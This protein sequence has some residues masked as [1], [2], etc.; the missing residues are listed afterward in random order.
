MHTLCN[1]IRPTVW[2]AALL[3]ILVAASVH[4]Q[5]TQRTWSSGATSGSWA[6][7]GNWSGG[8]APSSGNSI[9]FTNNAQTTMTNDLNATNRYTGLYMH[10]AAGSDRLLVGNFNMFGEFG[11]ANSKIEVNTGTNHRTLTISGNVSV[12]GNTNNP[13]EINPVGGSIIIGGSISDFGSGRILRMF[14]NNTENDLVRSVTVSNGITG[15]NG[16]LQIRNYANLIL[17]G[18]STYTNNTEIDTG[19]VMLG[20]GS[21]DGTLNTNS[22]IYVGNG[23][24]NGNATLRFG[25][26]NGGQ[27]L[28]AGAILQI[29]ANGAGGIRT[30]RS[31]NTSG[32][33]TI[34]RTINN[35]AQL[36]ITNSAGGTLRFAG[37]ITNSANSLVIQGAGTNAVVEFAAANSFS[38]VFVDYGHVKFDASNSWGTGRISLGRN[39]ADTRAAMASFSTNLTVGAAFEAR[40]NASRKI[41]QYSGGAGTLTLTGAITNNASGTTSGL[42]LDVASGGT[43]HSSGAL[44]GGGTPV[45]TKTGAGVF[46]ASGS[47]GD[48][49]WNIANGTVVVGANGALSTG[50]STGV[51]AIDLGF[52]GTG[53]TANNVALYASNGV[54]VSNSIYVAP[55]DSSSTRTIGVAA[56]SAAATFNNEIYLHGSARLEAGA[57]SQATFSGNLINTAG[58]EKIGAGTVTLSGNNT[59]SGDTLVSAGTLKLD[60]ASGGALAATDSVSVDDTAVLLLSRSNQVNDSAAVTLSGGT[61]QRDGEV[62]E[63]FGN[64]NLTQA[65][66][67][68]YGSG[69]VGQLRFGTYSAEFLLTVGNFAAGNTLL[70]GSDLTSVITDTEL[71]SFGSEISYDWDGDTSTFTITAIPE[72]SA[73]AAAAGLLGMMLWP[74]RR[75][76]V[77]D[78]KRILG[79]RAP[80][81]DRLRRAA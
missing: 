9:N 35:N 4:A 38:N 22:A 49:K 2:V 81:R 1:V 57:S 63:V 28:A 8:T 19:T 62:N 67:L 36:F 27:T 23:A 68:D 25:K 46:I 26:T 15:G 40:T 10:S 69:P 47:A 61:I 41:I 71:F 42:E 73:Y 78:T 21:N 75:R 44:T 65:S 18:T 53:S 50:T 54:T 12:G 45:F 11:G 66:F 13:Y 80:M 51:R 17:M 77:R 52:D 43:M 64:L 29:N 55:N 79:L 6:T 14:G 24:V 60:S 34:E 59:F 30:I 33:N 3:S 7:S 58:I 48:N 20:Q 31:D 37:A 16:T 70:F 39:A 72:P 56:S 32:T 76:I 74:A 5:P